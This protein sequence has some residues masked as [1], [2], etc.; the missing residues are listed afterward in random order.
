MT[1]N[2]ANSATRPTPTRQ[3]STNPVFRDENTSVPVT[4]AAYTHP[5]PFST[6]RD[7]SQFR[8]TTDS[9]SRTRRPSSPTEAA[10][11]ASGDE[12][13]RRLSLVEERPGK[14][15]SQ[16]ADPKVTHANLHLSGNV[17][18]ATFC[19]PY[20]I[21]YA[22]GEDWVCKRAS[23]TSLQLTPRRK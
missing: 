19:V 1:D 21:S 6:D 11:G 16:D 12:L 17:I 4:P 9:A 13:L 5:N 2:Q 8:R 14:P 18:S 3:E 23:H 7:Q 20:K 10:K 15:E 22:S